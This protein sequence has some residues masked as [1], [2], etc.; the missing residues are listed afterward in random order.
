MKKIL[1]IAL[2]GA[3]LFTLFASTDGET[4]QT[5]GTA[6][7]SDAPT[8][9]ESP[10]LVAEGSAETPAVI[11]NERPNILIAYFSAPEN[12][13]PD[14]VDAISRASIVVNDDTTFGNSQYIADIIRL[15]TG[16]DVF[17]IETVQTYPGREEGLLDF[18]EEEKENGIRPEL[19]T[20]LENIDDYDIIFLGYPIW[21]ADLPMPLYTFLEEYDLSG[22]TIIPFCPHGGSGFAGTVGTIAALQ[23]GAT[24]SENG[25]LISR[26][27]VTTGEND[28]LTWLETLLLSAEMAEGA[29]QL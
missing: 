14:D 27:D 11:E 29:E 2:S 19:S 28:V 5:N 9:N 26:D 16:G 3:L 8:I 1:S 24:V 4:V 7:P 18:A 20:Q 17:R 22:K 13:V 6:T 21:H 15:K 12:T 23:P 25:F 10:D